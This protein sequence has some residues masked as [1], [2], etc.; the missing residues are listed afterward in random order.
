[1]ASI[2]DAYAYIAGSQHLGKIVL[3]AD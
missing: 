1:M 2:S 3:V